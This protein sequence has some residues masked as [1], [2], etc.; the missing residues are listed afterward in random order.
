MHWGLYSVPAYKSE[1][2]EK[3][4]YG[5]KDIM[6]GHREHFGPQD[7]F[8]Y[9]D[10]IPM[11]KQD[12]FNADAW[13]ELFKKSGAKFVL[14]KGEVDPTTYITHRVLLD[15]VKD[16]FEHWLNPAN[17]VIKAMVEIE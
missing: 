8:G 16:E 15:N 9:K 5:N 10:F 1:W 7:K 14:K 11:F 2:H 17:G 4:M 3:H 13:A 6:A 12:K